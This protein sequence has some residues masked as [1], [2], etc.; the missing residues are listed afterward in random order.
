MSKEVGEKAVDFLIRN[1]GNRRNLEIDFFGGEPLMNL[2][3]V[4]YIVDYAKEKAKENN[5]IF[6]FTLTTN[7]LLLNDK[8]ADYLNKEMKNIVLSIDGR[9]DTHNYVRHSLSGKDCYDIIL[10]NAQSFR[11]IRGNG[12]Y[13]VRGTFT[14]KNLDFT[15]DILRLNDLGFDQI[16]L[17]PVVLPDEHKLAIK[18]EHL[19]VIEKEYEK[20]AREYISRRKNDK[21]F[22]FFHYMIDLEHG[23]CVNKRLT[24]CGA[25]NEYLAVS[26][27]G[28]IFPCH[29]FV[30][31]KEYLLGDVFMGIDNQSKKEEFSENT[32]LTKIEC[33][34]C[35]AKY[36]CGGG[37]AANAKNATGKISG[38]YKTGC[39]LIKKRLEMSLAIYA[40][41]NNN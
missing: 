23:P 38:V 39:A 34:N 24:G 25:G 4:K 17:E 10:S 20:L 41:E 21:W 40:I 13:Y 37:C 32:L 35:I 16:S 29:Q 33:A 1:S 36:F 5:K 31:E 14:N 2:D 3:V 19:D 27:T 9:R 18:K 8:N 12:N 15:E 26:P 11:K 30:G 22:N 7:C 28:D 6:S